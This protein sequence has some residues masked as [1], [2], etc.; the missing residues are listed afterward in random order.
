MIYW[1]SDGTGYILHEHASTFYA[2]GT[3]WLSIK[4]FFQGEARYR[5]GRGC[6]AINDASYLVLNHGQS[7]SVE[8]ESERPVESF[9]LF[10]SPEFVNSVHHSLITPIDSALDEAN[11]SAGM[12]PAF[13]ERAY[14]HD[15][16]LS[17]AL[18]Q[19][20]ATYMQRPPSRAW[21]LEQFHII[22]ERLLRVHNAVQI[23]VDALPAAR[24]ATRDE[25][26]RR[27]YKAKDYADALFSSQ[28]TLDDL[29][30]VAGISP[31]HLLRTFKQVFHQSPYQYIMAQRFAHA[32]YLLRHTDR[33]ITDICFAVGFE[34]LSSFSW[35]FRRRFGISPQQY[36]QQMW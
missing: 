22:L 18:L 15:A 10:L 19:L 14:P 33:A 27:I 8:I 7:Y 30:N 4:S 31:N 24:A 28:I 34:S 13:F 1:L 35:L 20:R 36:R 6:Y 26:Y 23:E 16:I 5:V 17:P 12:G 32:Q 9:C 25:L 3:G 29:A 2:E 21:L 11:T